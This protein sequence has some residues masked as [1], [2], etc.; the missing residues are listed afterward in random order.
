[1][2]ASLAKRLP[3]R[4]IFLAPSHLYLPRCQVGVK[5]RSHLCRGTRFARR[6]SLTPSWSSAKEDLAHCNVGTVGHV[7]HGK[8]TLTAAITKTLER[9]G[10]AKFVPFDKIDR[11]PEEKAR[12]ITINA[13]HV[14]YSSETRHY[15]HTDC[16]GH[17][18][19]IKNM[20][21]GTS[22]MDG[23]IVVVDATEGTMPQ[24]REH[25]LL[26]KQIGVESI[27]VFINKADKAD[28]EMLE[29]V[30]LEM[31]DLLN[32]FG[33]DGDNLPVI[34][35]S[36]LCALNETNPEIGEEA[37]LKLVQVMDEYII[38][39]KRDLD[40]PFCMPIESAITVA[41]RGTVVIGTLRQGIL[42][43]GDEVCLLGYGNNFKTVASDLQVFRK[44]LR[45]VKAGDNVGVLLRGFKKEMIERGMFLSQPGYLTEH[46]CFKA[47]VYVQRKSEGGRSKP[48]TDN[49]IQMMFVDT[50]S[51]ACCVQLPDNVKMIMPGDTGEVTI[52]L[53]KPMVVQKGQQFIIRESKSTTLTGVIT[54][55]FPHSDQ[56]I[57]GFNFRHNRPVK[58]EGSQPSK[59]NKQKSS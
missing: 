4:T 57:S 24:T 32:D 52:L 18:D 54:E 26:A 47:Q 30:E 25:L 37:I 19:Y 36:A 21:T 1:M 13:C 5:I 12:G 8:T 9:K 16:P 31:R 35:G 44:S 45:E 40:K 6:F 49:Y 15:A 39:P 58:I 56:Q 7:D 27:I 43:K 51:M 34:C 42:K 46:N 33:F 50:W 23:A 17:I 55:T 22:Q 29:L 14:E 2:A 11:A 53:R 10:L 41:G 20:I 38:P 48:V 59:S 3:L 28:E